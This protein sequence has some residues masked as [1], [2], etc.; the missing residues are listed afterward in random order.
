MLD[1]YHRVGL[2]LA[3][4]VIS[5]ALAWGVVWAAGSSLGLPAIVAMVLF[6]VVYNVWFWRHQRRQEGR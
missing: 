4:T 2:W 3:G 5:I 1:W 6:Q